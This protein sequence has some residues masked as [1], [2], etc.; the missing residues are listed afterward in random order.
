M[1]LVDQLPAPAVRVP[2]RAGL[3]PD[4]LYAAFTGWVAGQGISL[5]PAQDVRAYLTTLVWQAVAAASRMRVAAS[6]IAP[7]TL[8]TMF[9]NHSKCL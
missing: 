7:N 3:D 5:Y 4:E 1:K 9:L 8:S 2:G 6:T